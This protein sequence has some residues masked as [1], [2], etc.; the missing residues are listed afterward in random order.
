MIRPCLLL[1]FSLLAGLIGGAL[2]LGAQ[3]AGEGR[4][5]L[6]GRVTDAESGLAV[7]DATVRMGDAISV[8]DAQGLFRFEPV[9]AG[10]YRVEV[11]HLGYGTFS[12][13]LEL[14]PPTIS[15][16]IRISPTA[17]QLDPV[18]VTAQTQEELTT[19]SRGTRRNVVTR[20]V[21]ARAQGTGTDLAQ[22]LARNVTGV[23]VRQGTTIG[24]P[25]CV[26]FRNVRTIQGPGCHEPMVILDGVRV[27]AP[28]YLYGSLPLEEVERMELLAPGEAGATYGTDTSFGVLL[29]TT[30]TAASV[31]GERTDPNVER[32]PQ[33]L[34]DWSLEGQRYR[35]E[36]VFLASALA[37]AAGLA[38]GVAVGR[39][40]LDFSGLSQHFF[41]SECGTV[42]T[43]GS[44]LLL[45]GLPLLGTTLGSRWAG[46]TDLSRGRWSHTMLAAA[47]VGL[48]GYILATSGE[49]DAFS[50]AD[51][52]GRGLLL[53]G[54]PAM[55]TVA[56]RLFRAVREP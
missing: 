34:Y 44:R 21:I 33:R 27:A 19:R 52:M 28:R 41:D 23:Q 1:A 8:T 49:Q 46:D 51:W 7:P 12:E 24:A 13:S 9:A 50:G 38:L 45:V 14:V 15:L 16:R 18:V 31:L 54:V 47:L 35:W 10:T 6:Y 2:P 4:V 42:G 43:A 29:I 39:S 37:N 32:V 17:I 40:C 5:V 53:V 25:I 11:E 36:K 48:P 26:E 20:E 56:D 30:R 22:L 55:A 3:A